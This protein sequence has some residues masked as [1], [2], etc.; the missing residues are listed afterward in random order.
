MTI[1]YNPAYS[2]SP[3]REGTVEFDN[4]YCGDFQLMQRLLFFSGVAYVPFAD[5]AR[6]AHYHQAVQTVIKED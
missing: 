1:Y 3:Y 5:E 4:L 2:S 6:L